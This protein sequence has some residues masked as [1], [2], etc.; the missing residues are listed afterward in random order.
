M[1]PK[2]LCIPF[3]I[4]TESEFCNVRLSKLGKSFLSQLHFSLILT[5]KYLLQRSKFCLT[6]FLQDRSG[7]VL[8]QTVWDSIRIVACL[9][10]AQRS[11]RWATVTTTALSTYK[12]NHS[13]PRRHKCRACKKFNGSSLHPNGAL[14]RYL[15]TYYALKTS[16]CQLSFHGLFFHY[17]MGRVKCMKTQS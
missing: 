4:E 10:Y 1:K 2:S 6:K 8:K 15:A 16:Y 7:Q 9:N 11:F 12:L 5:A 17:W 13:A 3:E 14:T